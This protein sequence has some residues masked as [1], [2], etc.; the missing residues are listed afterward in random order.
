L[1]ETGGDDIPDFPNAVQAQLSSGFGMRRDPI[2]HEMQ[3]S[4]RHGYCR[5]ARHKNHA[6]A[7]G[8]PV[9]SGYSKTG[10]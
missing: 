3:F 6:A 1:R 8:K 5:A 7:A 9:F 4:S 10:T 2:T